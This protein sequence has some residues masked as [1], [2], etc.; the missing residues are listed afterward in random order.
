MLLIPL[1]LQP[2]WTDDAP[3]LSYGAEATGALVH[4]PAARAAW[5]FFAEG[6]AY[7]PDRAAWVA[8]EGERWPLLFGTTAAPDLVASAFFW[9]SGWQEHTTRTRDR[10]GRFPFAAS[11]QARWGT[12]TRPV[13]DAYREWLA[14]R[15]EQAG[16]PL[17]RR[18]WGGRRWAFCPTHDIDYLRK[19]RPG[20]VYREVVPHALLGRLGE[21]PAARARRFGRVVRDWLRPGDR[22]RQAFVRIRER[23]AAHEGTAT[24]FLKTGAH[25]PHDVPYR[26]DDPF[27][28]REVAT[29]RRDGF[30]VGLHPSFFAH[31]HADYLADERARLA[32]LTGTA[33][34]SVRQ[35]YL[36]Y[37]PP[38]TPRLHEAAGFRIDSTLGFS[39]H[40]GF[41]H[42]T[43]LPFRLFDLERNREMDLWEMPL[44]LMDGAAFNR[45]GLDVAGALDVT[46]QLMDTCR[47]F[48]GAFVGLWH[49][50][51]WDELDAPG[52]GAHFEGSLALGH[53][54]G[55]RITSLAGGL[56]AWQPASA[57]EPVDPSR[58]SSSSSPLP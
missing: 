50:V 10:F 13:V 39:E 38:L 28:R 57:R 43:C 48:G 24:F 26:L 9:L 42:G 35:H 17:R 20:I 34:H 16:L 49:N 46:A 12:A 3:E 5:P 19:W 44:A 45:R 31:Q 11:L 51:L 14:E 54:R 55:P 25:G 40:E 21:P 53:A 32:A 41:R 18:T 8:W 4:V 33:P 29:L 2:R 23:V 36:R 30:E 15:L 47:R 58:R 6:T 56:E 37:D 27:L 22:Y 52:W 7:P 1:G